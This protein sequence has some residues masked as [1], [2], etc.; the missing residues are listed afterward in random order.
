MKAV[1]S[2]GAV[3]IPASMVKNIFAEGKG[4]QYCVLKE[5]IV[6]DDG[7]EKIYFRVSADYGNVT[8]SDFVRHVLG[9]E[10]ETIFKGQTPK[11]EKTGDLMEFWLGI[12]ELAD[13]YPEVFTV[14]LGKGL[15]ECLKGLEESFLIFN[16]SCRNA[17]S[18]NSR[19]KS[20]YRSDM[21]VDERKA[22][23]VQIDLF[24]DWVNTSRVLNVDRYLDAKS[25]E[26]I[27]G[28]SEKKRKGGPSDGP[29]AEIKDVE[30]KVVTDTQETQAMDV[31][32]VESVS[33]P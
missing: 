19:K 10:F 11:A 20:P 3:R 4:K 7:R 18:A 21:S 13:T 24:T 14:H 12:F 32:A 29:K 16:S 23:E 15:K 27:Y 25:G 2:Y 9:D 17:L 1:S 8:Y 28:G 26:V 31:D 22:A 33:G 6:G 30:M 5:S